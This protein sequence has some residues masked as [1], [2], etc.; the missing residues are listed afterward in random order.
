[1]QYRPL[2]AGASPGK[3]T[4]STVSLRGEVSLVVYA[5]QGDEVRV[6]LRSVQVGRYAGRPMPVRIVSP[7]GSEVKT[8]ETAFL[9]ETPI[10]FTAP[11]TGTFTI[12]LDTSQNAVQV[13]ESTHPLCLTSESQP[14]HFIGAVGEFFFWVPARTEEFGVKVFGEGAGEGVKAALYDAAGSLVEERDNITRPHVFAVDRQPAGEGQVWRLRLSKPSATH[15]EDYHVD[16]RGVPPLLSP[17]EAA[18]LVP[19]T[20]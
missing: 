15:L 8:V 19:A 2:A 7:S 6:N 14:I 18:L 20:D 10:S 12:L 5:Q 1:V 11:D 4:G 9:Q 3:L 16:L 13:V 17:G